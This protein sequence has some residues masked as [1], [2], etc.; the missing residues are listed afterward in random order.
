MKP[1]RSGRALLLELIA[2][3]AIPET[4]LAAFLDVRKAIAETRIVRV[5]LGPGKLVIKGYPPTLL[6]GSP[7]PE[8]DI[9]FWVVSHHER[10]RLDTPLEDDK[11]IAPL[12][13][14][15]FSGGSP[16]TAPSAPLWRTGQIRPALLSA[17]RQTTEGSRI[18]SSKL[19]CKISVGRIPRRLPRCAIKASRSGLWI[20][21]DHRPESALFRQDIN[22]IKTM[23]TSHYPQGPH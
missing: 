18:D 16:F 1:V 2:G 3:E 21:L 19:V 11:P 7:P 13:R 22:R 6:G 15:F 12:D 17:T 23:V 10:T 14:S 20:V 4:Q 5:T 9:P 8:A